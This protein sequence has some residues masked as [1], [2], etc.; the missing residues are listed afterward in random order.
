MG[1]T[2]S[3]DSFLEN[4]DKNGV[5]VA[6]WA[7]KRK[8]SIAFCTICLC[9]V[10]FGQGSRCLTAHSEREKHTRQAKEQGQ[11][12]L[13]QLT[14]AEALAGKVE[15][16]N[17]EKEERDKTTEFE[18]SLVRALSNH[19]I[20]NRFLNC[21]ESI[22]KKHC[23]DSLVVQRMKLK[24][25]KGDYMAEHGI[26]KTYQDETIRYLREC[27]SFSIGF[28]ESEIN[29]L[30]ELEV[31]V[32]LAHKTHGILLRHYRT[33][34]LY[35]GTAECI[36]E[37]ILNSFDEDGVDY[38]KKMIA[39]MTDGCATMEGKKSGVKKRM[40]DQVEGLKDL[41]SCN[42]HH[43]SNSIQ[44]GA[45]D[46][47]PDMQNVL[48]DLYQDIGGAKGKGTKKMKEFKK[49]CE[50]IGLTPK[51]IKKYCSTRFR[52]YRLCME[53]VEH[54]WEGLVAY[55]SKVKKANDRQERLK[56]FFVER[57]VMSRLKLKF[58][59]S[60]TKELIDGIDFFEKRTELLHSSRNKMEDILRRQILKFHEDP[61]VKNLD[62]E[63]NTSSKKSGPELLK[64]D[65]ENSETLLS[66]RSVFIG[67]GATNMIKD[68]GLKPDSPQLDWFMEAV[69]RFHK[70]VAQKLIGYFQTALNST[71]LDYMSALAPENRTNI[72]TS[73]QFKF[74]AKSFSKVVDNIR[75]YDGM[76][77]LEEEIDKYTVDDSFKSE[78]VFENAK[79]M[80]YEEYWEE[81]GKLQEGSWER[82]EILPRFAK[83][84]GTV[85]NSNSE[86]E[87]AF[88]VQ[89][90]IHRNPKKNQMSQSSFDSHMQIHYE[91][92]SKQSRAN[93]QK[94]I[95][96]EHQA[97]P[98]LHC[99]C[100]DA[101]ITKEMIVNCKEASRALK[102]E[103]ED[104]EKTVE[105]A[106]ELTEKQ[107]KAKEAME[108]RK[109]KLKSDIQSRSTFYKPSLMERIYP[110]TKKKKSCSEPT[111]KSSS[112]SQSESSKSSASETSSKSSK[113]SISSSK[114]KSG[115]SESLVRKLF[116]SSGSSAASGPSSFVSSGKHS[117][118]SAYI[119]WFVDTLHAIMHRPIT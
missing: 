98:K 61:A 84:L 25:S 15:C 44:H 49:V 112:K 60:A 86:T 70:K 24:N 71:D 30:C 51:P 6:S 42:G 116:R 43:I 73:Y 77:K 74:L 53:P 109:I 50:D 14:V 22:L 75:S 18:I 55:Y 58:L 27:D 87:R 9:E 34:D 28:D 32:K 39:S 33:F 54:N 117:L 72:V 99:H 91:V 100:C 56:Q 110:D 88:S 119:A 90:D 4:K 19:K 63:E 89:S 104:E 20:S 31:L 47:C 8:P 40:K 5:K 111:T 96:S 78:E 102:K 115:S 103:E 106:K 1:K 38:K 66:K 35:S 118:W 97:S 17:K 13:V 80:K 113:S 3:L 105:A 21:L 11:S 67:Q 107:A 12:N 68:L 46:F 36:T 7:K 29:K 79:E 93:C 64:V 114:S 57:E 37:T 26:G 95:D 52:T 48:V 59:L 62:E 85:F 83:A 76:D 94:C 2:S 23:G 45:T 101:E 81:V 41:G 16:E 10:N 108:E 65:L 92:E 69:F 82:Y